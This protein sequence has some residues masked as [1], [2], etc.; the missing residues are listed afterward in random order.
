MWMKT[1]I[2]FCVYQAQLSKQYYIQIHKEITLLCSVSFL[3]TEIVSWITK[4]CSP[5]AH[6]WIS[7]FNNHCIPNYYPCFSITQAYSSL[8]LTRIIGIWKT[9]GFHLAEGLKY[10]IKYHL[11]LI[12]HIWTWPSLAAKLH[13]IRKFL[14]RNSKRQQSHCYLLLM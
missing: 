10:Y 13:I 9:T 2:H 4:N 7:I 8:L 14:N 11:L 6:S 12:D 3:V 5:R 1:F